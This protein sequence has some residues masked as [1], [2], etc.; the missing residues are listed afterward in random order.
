MKVVNVYHHGGVAAAKAAGVVYCGRPST[1]G[2]PCSS[3]GAP[4]P[5]CGR[6]HFGPG[7]VQLTPDRSIPCYRRW[8]W[9]RLKARDRVII[10]A[11]RALKADDRLGC[12]CSPKTCHLDVVVKAWE[13][14]KTNRIF[15]EKS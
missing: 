7:M 9:A 6:V 13:W 14:C 5:V 10:D 12:F 11:L 2:N 15:E 8:L 4:C 1:L 3:P